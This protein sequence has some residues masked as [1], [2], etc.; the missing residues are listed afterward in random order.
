MSCPLHPSAAAEYRH[1]TTRSVRGPT[2]V[3]CRLK[4]LSRH[5]M[6]RVSRGI[7]GQNEMLSA[8]TF[9]RAAK[10]DAKMAGSGPKPSESETHLE[11]RSTSMERRER[12]RWFKTL[13]RPWLR[14]PLLQSALVTLITWFGGPTPGAAQN[15]GNAATN[16][17]IVYVGNG[18]GG[19][20]E[21]NAA[22]N[23]VIATAPFPN[24]ANG[25]VVT[26]D[27]Q[28]IY[29]SN[30]DVGQVTVFDAAT[31]VPITVIPVGNG[32]DNLG[33]AISPDGTLVYV[34]NQFSG[35]VTVV[36]TAT[37]TVVQTIPTGIEP[38]W[39]TFSSDGSRAYVSNQVSGTVS[40]VSTA[41]GTVI[42]SI[43]GFSCP[44]HSKVTLDGS[45]LLVS[46]Q[47]DSSLKVVSLASNSIVNSIPTGPNPRGIALTADG[48]RAYV[49]DWFSNTVDVIDVAAQVNLNTPI[50]VG[51]NP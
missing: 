30:R 34:A 39:V 48:T 36:A 22:N 49:A 26:P 4:E 43:F 28:R 24:N 2:V 15:T 3:L 20:T 29:A 21:I 6:L 12:A 47:C 33:L 13:E 18:G 14:K 41:S 19:I 37:N 1:L 42:A 7:L 44:F 46:S 5:L 32:N 51:F 35:T 25:I 9:A 45:K 17:P 50:T 8:V 11:K 27:G 10:A 23:S 40:V 16:P 38:I 31:N